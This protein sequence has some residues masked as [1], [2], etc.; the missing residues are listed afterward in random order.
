[1][2]VFGGTSFSGVEKWDKVLFILGKIII[3]Q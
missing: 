1:M 3:F 2:V